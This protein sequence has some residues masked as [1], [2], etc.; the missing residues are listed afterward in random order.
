MKMKKTTSLLIH[1]KKRVLERYGIILYKDDL[2]HLVRMIQ[3]GRGKFLE[4]E[5]VRKTLWELKY[6]GTKFR[7]VYDK[8]RKAIITFL[9]RE[10]QCPETTI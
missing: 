6:K 5:S 4:K 1:A 7:V 10:Q 2:N 3:D 8:D 9:P